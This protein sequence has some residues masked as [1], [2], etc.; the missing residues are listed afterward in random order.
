MDVSEN[1]EA[2][3]RVLVED[4]A[5]R[6]VITQMLAD[7]LVIGAHFLHHRADFFS[8]VG[9]GVGGEDA[10]HF[11][12]VLSELL[13]PSCDLLMRSRKFGWSSPPR[14]FGMTARSGS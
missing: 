3:F 7:K 9:A 8:P 4:F 11:V 13:H 6:I 14:R 2:E 10:V 5:L 12:G 1:A